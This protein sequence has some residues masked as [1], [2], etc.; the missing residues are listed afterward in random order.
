LATLRAYCPASTPIALESGTVTFVVARQLTA[1]GFVPAVIDAH[2]VRLKAHRPRQ[3]S[4]R[5]LGNP[6]GPRSPH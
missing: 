2:E 6:Y 4:D 1:L 3:K 5:E